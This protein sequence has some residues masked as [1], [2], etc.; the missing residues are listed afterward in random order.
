[1]WGS[2]YPS[3]VERV[4][5][6]WRSLTVLGAKVPPKPDGAR[7]RSPAAKGQLFIRTTIMSHRE[8]SRQSPSTTAT[9][10]PEALGGSETWAPPD[11]NW[12]SSGESGDE[13]RLLPRLPS[14]LG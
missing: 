10:V 12:S 5:I 4:R 11:R 14:P 6:C 8:R 7:K 2:L 13:T 9:V 3:S 1:M